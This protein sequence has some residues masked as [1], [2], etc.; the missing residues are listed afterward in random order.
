M[1][2]VRHDSRNI[3][4]V[5][6]FHIG[7]HKMRLMLPAVDAGTIV[8]CPV[9]PTTQENRP[10]ARSEPQNSK[11]DS[12]PH[13]GRSVGPVTPLAPQRHG[14]AT[15]SPAVSRSSPVA[16]YGFLASFLGPRV[17]APRFVKSGL[18]STAIIINRRL[19]PLKTLRTLNT[20]LEA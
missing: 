1:E 4:Y 8:N 17:A 19:T 7:P 18:S 13:G 5:P 15:P 16:F 2:D 6:C 14:V 11:P 12:G 20:V 9:P 10:T 3:R